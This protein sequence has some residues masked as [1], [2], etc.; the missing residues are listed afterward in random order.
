M[1]DYRKAIDKEV[2][3]CGFA[4]KIRNLQWVQFIVLRNEGQRIQI[5]IEKSEDKNA[6]MIKIVDE[7]TCE[8]TIK[9]KGI[10]KENEHVK[11][12]GLELIP[13]SIEVTSISEPELPINIFD[14]TA[15][16][17]D[18]RMDNRFLDLRNDVNFYI[19]KI[20]SEFVKGMRQYLYENDFTEIHTP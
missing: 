19:N 6:D 11:M 18:T 15:A 12:G 9:V 14:K 17:I 2:T 3:L 16:N 7:L 1:I 4:E 8:S 10:I 13:S 20:Q 5:T